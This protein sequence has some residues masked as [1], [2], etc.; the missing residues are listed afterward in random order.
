MKEILLWAKSFREKEGEKASD[1]WERFVYSLWRLLDVSRLEVYNVMLLNQIS[2]L[3]GIQCKM[4]VK[5]DKCR[6]AMVPMTK[7]GMDAIVTLG[8]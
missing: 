6:P 2:L 7:K 5:Q 3:S 4:A 1:H 8:R